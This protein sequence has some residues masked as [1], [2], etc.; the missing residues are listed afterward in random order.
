MEL[1]LSVLPLA[2]VKQIEIISGAKGSIHG[3]GALA[4]VNITHTYDGDDYIYAQLGDLQNYFNK[5]YLI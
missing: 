1:L 4:G 2:D 5:S 3:S